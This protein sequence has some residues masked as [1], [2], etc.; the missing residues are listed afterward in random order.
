MPYSSKKYRDDAEAVAM[1]LVV[2]MMHV[3]VS[4]M[5]V[6]VLSACQS[7]VAIATQS[8]VTTEQFE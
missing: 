5:S 2:M 3:L 1:K 4:C 8:A 6:G 7:N